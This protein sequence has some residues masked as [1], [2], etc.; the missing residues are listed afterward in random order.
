ML[1]AHSACRQEQL[2]SEYFTFMCL[3]PEKYDCCL[4]RFVGSN[5]DHEAALK[6]QES[7]HTKTFLSSLLVRK[8]AD[9]TWPCW[10][11]STKL[12]DIEVES[13]EAGFSPLVYLD[14]QAGFND[15]ITI[16]Q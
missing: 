13:K 14:L 8:V 6:L 5:F 10:L 7:L 11:R 16:R 2:Y 3:Q 1:N 9:L 12:A 4:G 15:V